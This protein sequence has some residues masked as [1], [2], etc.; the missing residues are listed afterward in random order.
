MGQCRESLYPLLHAFIESEV[1]FGPINPSQTEAPPP[2]DGVHNGEMIYPFT[3]FF[4]GTWMH[5]K[6]GYEKRMMW[7]L[8]CHLERLIIQQ[9]INEATGGIQ[10][11][12]T[13]LPDS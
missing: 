6:Q 8:D 11:L 10:C 12:K 2:S 9:V 1:C 13:P 5:G 3:N 4:F 7:F